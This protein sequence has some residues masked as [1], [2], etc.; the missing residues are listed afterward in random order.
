MYSPPPIEPPSVALFFEL[1]SPESGGPVMGPPM[2]AWLTAPRL[3]LTNSLLPFR[4][5][6]DNENPI[7]SQFTW[8]PR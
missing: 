2:T 7:L 5:E 4:D 8:H 6:E 1:H 3:K